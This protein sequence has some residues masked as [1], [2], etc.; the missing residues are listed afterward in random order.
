MSLLRSYSPQVSVA[1]VAP[2]AQVAGSEQPQYVPVVKDSA[3]K[4]KKKYD[5]LINKL[6]IKKN[7]KVSRGLSNSKLNTIANRDGWTKTQRSRYLRF[8]AANDAA[9]K[10]NPTLNNALRRLGS[11]YTKDARDLLESEEERRLLAENRKA[12]AE[13]YVEKMRKIRIIRRDELEYSGTD[14]QYAFRNDYYPHR[15]KMI[16]FLENDKVLSLVRNR[17]RKRLFSKKDLL[18]AGLLKELYEWIVWPIEIY[19]QLNRKYP[20]VKFNKIRIRYSEREE[21]WQGYDLKVVSLILSHL[22]GGIKQPVLRN[23]RVREE[24]LYFPFYKSS[25]K[26]SQIKEIEPHVERNKKFEDQKEGINKKTK[27]KYMQWNLSPHDYSVAVSNQKGS[28]SRRLW[29]EWGAK[30]LLETFELILRLGT[31]EEPS[32]V[33]FPGPTGLRDWGIQEELNKAQGGDVGV[34]YE[35]PGYEEGL[36]TLDSPLLVRLKYLISVWSTQKRL[37]NIT[38]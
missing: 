11:K 24:I 10:S 27:T 12:N 18:E 3:A 21:F 38:N 4:A 31:E 23:Q 28:F 29:E 22:L 35:W 2:V 32:L 26:N 34:N 33:L 36:F 14:E 16:R 9:R 20:D 17:P 7:G 37:V 6:V 5:K 1:P 15:K 13:A 25:F 19:E 30:E 8:R